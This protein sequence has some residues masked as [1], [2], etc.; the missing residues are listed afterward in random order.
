ML[1]LKLQYVG[2]L[3]QRAD[4]LERILMLGKIEGGRRRGQQRMRWLDGTTDSID[5]NLSKLWEI[6]EDRGAWHTAV[7]AVT[8]SQTWLRDWTTAKWTMPAPSSMK[9]YLFNRKRALML[10]TE[11]YVLYNMTLLGEMTATSDSCPWHPVLS[12]CQ[13]LHILI[14]GVNPGLP[15]CRQILYQLS[16]K[17]SPRILEWVAY[18][19]S[20]GSSQPRN[21]TGVSC[22]PGGFITNWAMR[23]ARVCSAIIYLKNWSLRKWQAATSVTQTIPPPSHTY[24]L[25]DGSTTNP[26][27]ENPFIIHEWCNHTVHK[28]LWWPAPGF[29]ALLSSG[30]RC[31]CSSSGFVFGSILPKR[32]KGPRK[33]RH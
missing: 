32:I 21:W 11:L 17:G 1:K 14:Q 20:R 4:S 9:L 12:Q 8:K 13:L 7:H 30:S 33:D 10:C 18:P 29:L 16:H 3:K 27:H 28:A 31:A 2:H 22:I 19:F 24:H 5:M 26:P 6:V 25:L 15:H 23:E